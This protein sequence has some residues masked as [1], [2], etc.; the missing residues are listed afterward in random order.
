M[1]ESVSAGIEGLQPGTRLCLPGES[2]MVVLRRTWRESDGRWCLLV[3]DDEDSGEVRIAQF[4]DAEARGIR[5]V[6]EDGSGSPAVVLTGLW[7]EWIL[8]SIRTARATALSSSSLKPLPHQMEAVYG[9]MLPQPLLRFLLAD[10]P[11]TGKTIM[12]GMWLREMQ[13]LGKVGRAL[14]VCPAHLVPKWQADF[15]KF[16]GGGLREVTNETIQQDA[17]NLSPD[18]TWVVSLHLAASNPAVREALRPERA[19]WDAVIFDEAH[20]M[21]PLAETFHLVGEALS[22]TDIHTVLLTATPHRGEEWLFREL[23]HLVDPDIFPS[24]PQSMQG[25]RLLRPGRLHFLRRMK[26]ELLDYDGSSRLF[27]EREARNVPVPLNSTEQHFYDEALRLADTY[28]PPRG[29]SLAAMVY[30]KRAASS[31][32]ALAETLRRRLDKMTPGAPAASDPCDP[33]DEEDTEERVLTSGSADAR[34]ERHA[35]SKVLAELDPLLKSD[36]RLAFDCLEMSKWD[37]VLQCLQRHEVTG[38]SHNQAVVFTEFADT[39]DWLIGVFENAGYCA[40]RYCGREDQHERT[41]IQAAF[42]AGEFQVIVSTD[43][44]NEGIDLQAAQVLI[45]WDIPWSL[46]RL[47]QR[48]G[49]I[50]RIGQHRKAWFYNVIALGTREGD[51]HQRLLDRL[52]EAANELDGRVFDCLDAVMERVRQQGANAAHAAMQLLYEHSA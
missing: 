18:T 33:E 50:H 1:S 37:D 2:A 23:L 10:E 35:I 30:G 32:Y 3:M 41:K 31:L 17:L 4:T 6:S 38:G 52:M 5:S 7:C 28:F 12:S 27:R 49:R 46:V 34:A 11:G 8:H 22:A 9:H 42:M 26:E 51:A 25:L 15:D 24:V 14:V 21:T 39:A 36:G 43:A 44:G 48:M 16:F 40:R 20:R 29:R 45:N 19:G 13:R 47:E